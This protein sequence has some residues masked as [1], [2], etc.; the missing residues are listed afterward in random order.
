MAVVGGGD[1]INDEEAAVPWISFAD[2]HPLNINA[3]ARVSARPAFPATS[4]LL[5]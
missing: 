2:P 1:V 4:M 3:I 5:T